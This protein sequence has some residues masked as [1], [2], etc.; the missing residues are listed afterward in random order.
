MSIVISLLVVFVGS[1]ML[2]SIVNSVVNNLFLIMVVN[3]AIVVGTIYFAYKKIRAKCS[4]LK[5]VKLEI[6]DVDKMHDD[7]I[8]NRQKKKIAF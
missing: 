6:S 5:A 4:E 3:T 8:Q 7:A 1:P 2:M